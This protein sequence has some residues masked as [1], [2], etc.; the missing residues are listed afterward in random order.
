[1]P[2]TDSLMKAIDEVIRQSYEQW[3]D[4]INET[5][6]QLHRERSGQLKG[7]DDKAK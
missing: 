5:I 4:S 7:L 2:S 6:E 1:M 3:G